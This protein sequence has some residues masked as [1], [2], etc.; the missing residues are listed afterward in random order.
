MNVEV[1]VYF[2][3]VSKKI[4]SPHEL[5]FFRYSPI[6]FLPVQPVHSVPLINHLNSLEDGLNF[7]TSLDA[8]N[9]RLRLE[10]AMGYASEYHPMHFAPG[11]AVIAA[12]IL[13]SDDPHVAR[14]RR[15][16]NSWADHGHW[17]GDFKSTCNNVWPGS[18]REK[19]FLTSKRHSTNLYRIWIWIFIF[20]GNELQN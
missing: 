3:H 18:G 17:A 10:Q 15:P 14:D 6:F 1:L 9:Q 8:R 13:L 11:K 2:Y 19:R 7:W 12:H 20:I 4:N 16:T 5:S